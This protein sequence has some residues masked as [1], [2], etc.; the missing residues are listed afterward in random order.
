MGEVMWEII[1]M[2]FVIAE[3]PV[4]GERAVVPGW[5]VFSVS[6]EEGHSSST[7]SVK[8]SFFVVHLFDS[9]SLIIMQ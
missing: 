8:V 3:C 5:H 9:F 2:I 7:W 4:V 1:I 6:H